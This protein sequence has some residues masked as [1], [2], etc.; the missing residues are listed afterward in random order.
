MKVRTSG[1]ALFG[2]T[3]GLLAALT[4]FPGGGAV[5]DF[6]DKIPRKVG[7]WAAVG[8]DRVYDRETLYDY[9]DGGA[10]VYL[11]FDFREAWTRKYADAGGRELALDI[12]DMGS[13]AEAFGIFSCDRQDPGASIGQDSEYGFGLLRFRQGRYFVTVT[14]S[15]EDE[16]VG[17]VILELGREVVKHLGPP[18]AGPDMLG[19]LPAAGLRPERTS[20]F[21]SNVNLNNRFFIS[22]ENILQ[23]DRSTDCVFAE[24]EAGAGEAAFL[25]LLR[26][27][28]AEKAGAA[29]RSFL[30]GYA[31]EAGADGLARAEDGKWVCAS[32]SGRFLAVVFE[33]PTAEWASRL[34]SSLPLPKK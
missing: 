10:E 2:A 12:Y 34:I 15:V 27:P 33:A 8:E 19:F 29:R 13:P 14:A 23:L 3:A 18:G 16:T 9:M 25:L 4:V 30:A 28:D 1:R 5:G 24:V 26:Y 6:S 11:A 32:L 22:S 31:P 20:Y 17:E 21:H 7:A